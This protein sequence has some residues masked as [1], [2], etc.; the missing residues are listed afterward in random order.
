MDASTT[1]SFHTQGKPIE[2]RVVDLKD[3]QTLD[4]KETE[5]QNGV[6]LFLGG[7]S[8]LRSFARQLI[9]AAADLN[10]IAGP[11]MLAFPDLSILALAHSCKKTSCPCYRDGLEEGGI[12][13]YEERQPQERD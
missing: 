9:Q 12:T 6:I 10:A 13:P 11:G 2:V 4:I 7:K 5:S 3:F 8:Q 1:L